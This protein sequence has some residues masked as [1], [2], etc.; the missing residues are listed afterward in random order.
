MNKYLSEKYA[1]LGKNPAKQDT[2]T[3]W[4]R[5]VAK[6]S[7]AQI[8]MFAVII[9]IIG[10]LSLQKVLPY[11]WFSALASTFSYAIAAVGF[12]LGGVYDLLRILRLCERILR[13]DSR[14]TWRNLRDSRRRFRML[15]LTFIISP[16]TDNSIIKA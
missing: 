13:A 14:D 4:V 11:S 12:C 16:L 3:K 10:N 2:L 7:L 9:F 5:G 15:F 1:L 6:S 8:V